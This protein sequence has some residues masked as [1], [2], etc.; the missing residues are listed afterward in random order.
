[1]I[2]T[3][4]YAEISGRKLDAVAA[5]IEKRHQ[6]KAKL[7][8]L[9][10]VPSF[11][12]RYLHAKYPHIALLTQHLDAATVGSSTG[13]LV[14]E[15]AKISGASGSII[16]HSERRIEPHLIEKVVR[17]LRE[18]KMLSIVCA[19]DPEEV[20][21]FATFNPDFVAVEP[22]ELIGTGRAVSSVSPSVISESRKALDRLSSERLKTRLLCG[23]GIVVGSDASRSIELGAEGILVASGVVLSKDWK[24]KIEE[25]SK[26]MLAAKL[27]ICG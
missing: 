15:I 2:N 19:R 11:D 21:R 5:F 7:R 27:Q 10:A 20:S 1:M 23:A 4:N 16:N 13:A 25:L 24:G 18:L 8:V 26:S 9:L 22:S 12:L 3:K 14:P 6:E 17:R